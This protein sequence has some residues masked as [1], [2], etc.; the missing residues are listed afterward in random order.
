MSVNTKINGQLVK[1]A[2]L[3]NSIIPLGIADIYSDEERVIGCWRDGKPIYQKCV[4][5]GAMP[6]AS[7][8]YVPHGIAGIDTLVHF[9]FFPYNSARTFLT[10]PYTVTASQYIN[11]QTNFI[12]DATNIGVECGTDRSAFS[13]YAILQYT[14]TTDTAGSGIWTPSGAQAV[15]YSTAEQ[16]IGTWINGET[17]YQKTFHETIPNASGLYQFT[18]AAI[19]NLAHVVDK[20]FSIADE[21]E[22]GYTPWYN[23]ATVL[24]GSQTASFAQFFFATNFYAGSDLYFTVKYTKSV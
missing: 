14:K 18:S 12:V 5:F 24:Y 1:S 9:E 19:P 10:M 13:G 7:A 23:N 20:D 2:G 15:H 3:Y 17:L 6:N 21:G 16:I 8:K 11:Y 22:G 4:D